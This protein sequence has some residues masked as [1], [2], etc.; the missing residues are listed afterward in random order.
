[1][2]T[3]DVIVHLRVHL[4]P[5]RVR[6]CARAIGLHED[7]RVFRQHARWPDEALLRPGRETIGSVVRCARD[8]IVV[9]QRAPRRRHEHGVIVNR[10]WCLGLLFDRVAFRRQFPDKSL[11]VR[12]SGGTVTVRMAHMQGAA[13]H[14]CLVVPPWFTGSPPGRQDLGVSRISVRKSVQG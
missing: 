1:M 10:A 4:S 8:R 12:G 14:P 9:S 3:P 5:G 11:K 6:R 7:R 2:A 13:P